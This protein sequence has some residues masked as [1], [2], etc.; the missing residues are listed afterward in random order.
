M[1]GIVVKSE[2]TQTRS[3]VKLLP[4]TNIADLIALYRPSTLLDH[5]ST[6]TVKVTF[7]SYNLMSDSMSLTAQHSTAY[8]STAQY[9]AAVSLSEA[10]VSE[11]GSRVRVSPPECLVHVTGVLPAPH[12]EHSLSEPLPCGSHS[13]L[14][15][16]TYLLEGGKT[17]STHHLCMRWRWKKGKAT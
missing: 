12:S 14:V 3:Q 4:K 7:H 5:Y 6:V 10:V 17:V 2:P 8:H 15:V 9:S 11:Q 16:K 1:S 13:L